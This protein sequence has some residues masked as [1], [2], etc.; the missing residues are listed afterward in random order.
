VTSPA[1]RRTAPFHPIG[2][3]LSLNPGGAVAEL[4]CQ[5]PVP[6]WK[7]TVSTDPSLPFVLSG[8]GKDRLDVSCQHRPDRFRENNRAE[9]LRRPIRRQKRQPQ[10]LRFQASAHSF[11][12]TQTAIYSTF[13]ILR[14]L[15]SRPTLRRF[16]A[17]S[18]AAWAMAVAQ[19]GG[20]ST[21]RR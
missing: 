17:D 5:R 1:G 15:I 20:H 10:R 16:R 21:W 13:N 9:N 11:L 4:A 2:R 18:D 8:L 6:G 3:I 14:H 7:S 19:V 12:T